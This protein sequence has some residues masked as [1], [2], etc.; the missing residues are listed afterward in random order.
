MQGFFLKNKTIIFFFSF[1]FYFFFLFF[2]FQETTRALIKLLTTGLLSGC[3]P[4]L[5][6]YLSAETFHKNLMV[7]LNEVTQKII[8]I[9]NKIELP[10]IL[11]TQIVCS[12]WVA[13]TNLYLYLLYGD[14]WGKR[15]LRKSYRAPSNL[16]ELS[17][18]ILDRLAWIDS[19]VIWRRQVAS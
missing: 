2:L 10:F 7:L 14:I 1:F 18:F 6:S 4:S 16:L 3:C 11:I 12:F 15:K 13:N 9:N 17:Y 19:H 5:R 8:A